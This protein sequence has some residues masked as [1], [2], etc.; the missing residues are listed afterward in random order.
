M[1]H[2]ETDPRLPDWAN[3]LLNK[4]P[5][6]FDTESI[7]SLFAIVLGNKVNGK[8][9]WG[10]IGRGNPDGRPVFWNGVFFFRVAFPFLVAFQFRWS[11][12]TTAK[13]LIQIMS[14][15]KP[16]GRFTLLT[17][18]VQSDATSA[19]GVLAPNTDQASGWDAGNH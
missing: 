10:R 3:N 9:S 15:W 1:K 11:G 19:E 13:S 2:E 12:S 7:V 8:W 4:W 5:F 18:R 17:L 6:L 16:N 14:G